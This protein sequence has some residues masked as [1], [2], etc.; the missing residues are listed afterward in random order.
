MHFITVC[1]NFELY[2]KLFTDNKNISLYKFTVFD[3]NK[4]NLGIPARY[5]YFLNNYDFSAKEWLVFCHE[6]FNLLE[7]NFYETLAKLDKNFIYGP[8]GSRL[9]EG[10]LKIDFNKKSHS[11]PYKD[12]IGSI[13]QRKKDGSD[14]HF[15]GNRIVDPTIVD[16]VDCCCIIVHSTLIE[17][18]NLRFDEY[19]SFDLYAEE[20]CMNAKENHSIE[21]KVLQIKCEHWSSGNIT[22]RYYRGINHLNQK[23]PKAL[24]A[25][26]CS[27]VGGGTLELGK[28][29]S[30]MIPYVYICEKLGITFLVNLA[31]KLAQILK[32][33]LSSF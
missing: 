22:E 6:D 30:D 32:L 7:S 17:K 3:N 18:F 33:K 16:T 26:T 10:V 11:F 28:K 31:L 20:F 9:V 14:P 23:Y 13:I 25:G 2:K 12:L 29:A 4:E 1:R 24:Y 21:S 8:I 15:V 19:L 5:N 27:F